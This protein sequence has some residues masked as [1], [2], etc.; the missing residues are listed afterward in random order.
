M[1]T[2]PLSDLFCFDLYTFTALTWF[3]IEGSIAGVQVS[4]TLLLHLVSFHATEDL[5]LFLAVVV[6]TSL[7]NLYISCM[8]VVDI[9]C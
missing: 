3:G 1:D 6:G 2:S 9:L 7:L 4:L 8:V 5:A